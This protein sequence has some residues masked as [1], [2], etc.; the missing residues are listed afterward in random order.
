MESHDRN[1]ILSLV[2]KD[3]RL[4]RLYQ[5]HLELEQQLD[6]YKTRVFLTD[7]EQ[8]EA[9]RLKK[10][11]LSGVDLMMRIVSEYRREEQR[12]SVRL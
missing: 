7:D 6:D 12:E 1:L 2:E 10:K 3:E 11:K 9:K 5:E 8:M 4:R